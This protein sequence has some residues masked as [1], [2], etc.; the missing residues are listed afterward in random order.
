MTSERIVIPITVIEGLHLAQLV[1]DFIELID[2][3]RGSA[4]PAIDRLTPTPYPDDPDSAADFADSTRED[5]LD[6]RL[7]EA[8]R[9]RA[10][11]GE[12]GGRADALDEA[13]PLAA[14]ELVVPTDEIDFWLRTLTA[15]RLV[16]ATR[17]GITSDEQAGE[18]GRHDVYDWLGYRLEL[19]IQAADEAEAG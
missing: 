10:A 1:D 19:L 4:D 8:R 7:I 18:D 16:I 2:T 11:L 6:R 5:L 13:D 15:I 3:S 9:V 17:L 14:R 12:V